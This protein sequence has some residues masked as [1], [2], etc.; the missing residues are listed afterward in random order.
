[1]CVQSVEDVR[2]G[3]MAVRVSLSEPFH[4]VVHVLGA[5]RSP[6]LVNGEGRS[7]VSLGVSLLAVP[8]DPDYCGVRP[9][10]ASEDQAVYIAVRKHKALELLEDKVY[11]L[12][13]GQTAFRN[14]RNEI[15][16]VRLE[17]LDETGERKRELIYGR[18]YTLKASLANPDSFHTMKVKSCIMFAPNTSE[19]ELTDDRGC[20][21]SAAVLGAWSYGSDGRTAEAT[22]AHMFRLPD[23]SEFHLQCD[24]ALCRGTC[25]KVDCDT[26][27]QVVQQQQTTTDEGV[28]RLLASTTGFVLDPGD[29]VMSAGLTEC[30]EWRFPWLVGLCI[31]LAILLLV[32][33]VVNIFLCSS[34]SWTCTKTEVV[35]KEPSEVEDYDPYKVGWVPYYAAAGSRGGY[36]GS[37]RSLSQASDPYTIVRPASSSK[38]P[39]HPPS[40]HRGRY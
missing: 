6:C 8:G 17:L 3:R 1:M 27:I 25:D 24:V 4:G 35:E 14:A 40:S 30:T 22:I 9:P 23:S 16:R 10:K 11:H 19:I 36:G 12:T 31:C 26:A 21:A 28:I 38:E 7:E 2:A 13:C 18:S 33:L 29:S 5:R 34:L 20:P 37:T 15:S 32:M 39:L